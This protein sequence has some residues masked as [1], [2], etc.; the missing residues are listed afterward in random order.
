M[1]DPLEKKKPEFKDK[2]NA[3]HVH[4]VFSVIQ[5]NKVM[6]AV[7]RKTGTSGD[8]LSPYQTGLTFSLIYCP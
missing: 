8:Q 1:A 3:V 2:E 4:T 6:N 5:T 7:C